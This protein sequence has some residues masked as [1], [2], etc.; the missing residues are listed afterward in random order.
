MHASIHPFYRPSQESPLVGLKGLDTLLSWV[1][2]SK[3]GRD[4]V[5]QAIDALQE[6][7][8]NVLLPDRRLVSLEARPAAAL[9][10]GKEGARH[11]LWWYVEDQIKVGQL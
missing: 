9:P 11:L 10:Q 4:V 5:R 6:L 3:G 7:F 2:R 1:S 8:L